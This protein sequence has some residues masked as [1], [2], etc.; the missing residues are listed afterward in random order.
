MLNS[1][2]ASFRDS[3]PFSS[4][5][6][7]FWFYNSHASCYTFL[8]FYYGW[9]SPYGNSYRTSVYYH[10]SPNRY[11]NTGSNNGTRT[12]G[13]TGGYPSGGSSGGGG[14]YRPTPP[15]S[16]GPSGGYGN[17]GGGARP[18]PRDTVERMP[19]KSLEISRPN[20]N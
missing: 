12:T 6:L 10:P 9:N 15:P 4:R 14:T 20:N 17:T 1:A 16:S 13:N 11:P 18:Q 2:F 8:P 5:R 3:D 7:G 19:R